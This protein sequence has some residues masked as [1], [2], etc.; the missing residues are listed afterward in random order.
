MYKLNKKGF[1]LVEL[2]AVIVI[3]S[4]LMLIAL[5]SVLNIM[6]NAKD[7]AFKDEALSF[8]S[9]A[10]TQFISENRQKTCG[11]Y[12]NNVDDIAYVD[13]HTHQISGPSIKYYKLNNVKNKDNY[14][15]YIKVDF[16]NNDINIEINITD[17]NRTLINFTKS[18]YKT[19]K[20]REMSIDDFDINYN[21]EE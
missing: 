8:I 5:P 16:K 13:E 6:N 7:D 20:P 21:T 19:A 2:L 12:Y 15:A 9:A 4:V 10:E 1:T 14:H 17:G 11:Y 18:D 3:L